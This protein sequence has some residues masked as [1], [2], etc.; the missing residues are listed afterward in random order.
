[1]HNDVTFATHE[2]D[3]T[4]SP[5]SGLSDDRPGETPVAFNSSI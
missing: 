4:N 3:V 2:A 5:L 1:M